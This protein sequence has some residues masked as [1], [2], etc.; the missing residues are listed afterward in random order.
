MRLPECDCGNP[1]LAHSRQ[2]AFRRMDVVESCLN[3]SARGL[4]AFNCRS[5]QGIPE[6]VAKRHLV[7]LEP[8]GKHRF[9][10]KCQGGIGSGVIEMGCAAGNPSQ[11]PFRFP[12]PVPERRSTSYMG[13]K[14][15]RDKC[16][17]PIL[18]PL[19]AP[20]AVVFWFLHLEAIY[21]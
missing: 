9:L 13:R 3:D 15:I 16:K 12:E 1:G 18:L 14:R 8:G 2:Q 20:G 17:M 4:Q 11:G 5:V 19:D 7:A 21:Y 6:Q 10:P